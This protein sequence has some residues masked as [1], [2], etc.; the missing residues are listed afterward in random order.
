MYYIR[1]KANIRK[2][3]NEC[4][5][6][7]ISKEEDI[8]TIYTSDDIQKVKQLIE[9]YKIR[10]IYVGD[11]ERRDLGDS[12]NHSLLQSLGTV[13]YPG[14]FNASDSGSESYIIKILD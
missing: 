3:I 6:R 2:L 12:L 11:I 13:V 5:I 4:I 9:K 10:Y 7:Q 14:G 1:H 8:I